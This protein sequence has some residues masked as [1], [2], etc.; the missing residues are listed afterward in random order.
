MSDRY[1]LIKS[2]LRSRTESAIC[3]LLT[4]I[5]CSHLYFL[6]QDLT[7]IEA[8]DKAINA[9]RRRADKCFEVKALSLVAQVELRLRCSLS[10]ND[11]ELCRHRRPVRWSPR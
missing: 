4:C 2:W 5:V 1:S 6:A 10:I 7:L 11:L 3:L 8:M 9:A